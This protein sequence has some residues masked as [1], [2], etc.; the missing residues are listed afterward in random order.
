MPIDAQQRRRCIGE[1]LESYA[2]CVEYAEDL[3]TTRSLG[4]MDLAF[5]LADCAEICL[6]HAA[7][8]TAERSRPNRY[9]SV[10]CAQVCGHCADACNSRRADVLAARCAILCGRCADSCRLISE[11]RPFEGQPIALS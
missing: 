2:A 11:S 8:L 5:L 9:L 4:E 10:V 6:A 3:E 7:S 1:C